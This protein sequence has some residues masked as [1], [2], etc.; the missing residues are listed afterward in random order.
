MVLCPEK[1]VNRLTLLAQRAI[2]NQFFHGVSPLNQTIRS[3][4]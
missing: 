4:E 2:G 3:Q 1:T